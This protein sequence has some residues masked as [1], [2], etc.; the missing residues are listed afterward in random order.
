MTLIFPMVSFVV[1]DYSILKGK[2]AL[3]DK[4]YNEMS[5]TLY[6]HHTLYNHVSLLADLF[7]CKRIWLQTHLILFIIGFMRTSKSVDN[8]I[9][10]LY[11]QGPQ[12]YR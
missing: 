1:P 10:N 7:S 2:K 11:K 9:Y 5:S 3:N 8:S 4:S 6:Q 12:L